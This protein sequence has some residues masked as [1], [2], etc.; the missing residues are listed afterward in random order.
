MECA[1]EGSGPGEDRGDVEGGRA[2]GLPGACF[3]QGGAVG[4]G[5]WIA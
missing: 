3:G 1:V 2:E 5:G 4:C